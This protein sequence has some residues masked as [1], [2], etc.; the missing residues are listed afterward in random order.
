MTL[1]HYGLGARIRGFPKKRI[2][3]ALGRKNARS[4]HKLA[5]LEDK[6]WIK[7]KAVE[8]YFMVIYIGRFAAAWL[9]ALHTLNLRSFVKRNSRGKSAGG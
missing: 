2:F 1:T 9:N 3:A 8:K 5:D 4:V 6:P 7:T